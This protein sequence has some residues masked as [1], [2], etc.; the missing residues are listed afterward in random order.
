M[1]QVVG[2]T[3]EF[4]RRFAAPVGGEGG[5]EVGRGFLGS[6]RADRYQSPALASQGSVTAAGGDQRAARG[7][8][9]GPKTPQVGR[10]GEIVQNDKPPAW[11]HARLWLEPSQKC[12]RGLI[13]I[14]RVGT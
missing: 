14:R 12:L 1:P 2:E 7:A 13:R 6:E 3:H 9:R 8:G 4:A 10:V 5:A 11:F